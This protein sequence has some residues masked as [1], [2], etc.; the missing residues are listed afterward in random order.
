[1]ESKAQLLSVKVCPNIQNKVSR[2]IL[3]DAIANPE[4]VS[5]WKN[6]SNK[7]LTIKYPRMVYDSKYNN[8]IFRDS[9]LPVNIYPPS[10]GRF[11]E[12]GID[13]K[14]YDKIPSDLYIHI[15]SCRVA[16]DTMRLD[17]SKSEVIRHQNIIDSETGF[18][19]GGRISRGLRMV[20]VL[21]Y[22]FDSEG[23]EIEELNKD[24]IKIVKCNDGEF[25]EG[26]LLNIEEGES[27]D[28]EL[29]I[30]HQFVDDR[31]PGILSGSL[32]II[33]ESGK[34][35][36]VDEIDEAAFDSIRIC[37]NYKDKYCDSLNGGDNYQFQFKEQKNNKFIFD[38]DYKY[39]PNTEAPL[40]NGASYL[41][42]LL[43]YP[44][45]TRST[46]YSSGIQ[47]IFVPDEDM[48]LTFTIPKRNTSCQEISGSG[49]HRI[50]FVPQNY[51][52]LS[53]FK[54]SVND[55]IDD[56]RKVSMGAITDN[57]SF[58]INEDLTQTYG[59][60]FDDYGIFSCDTPWDQ[61]ADC[62]GTSSVIISDQD[63]A[64]RSTARYHNVSLLSR[65]VSNATAHELGHSI[66]GLAD[67]YVEE[68][69]FSHKAPNC[70]SDSTCPEWLPDGEL[71]CF[72]GCTTDD[73]YRPT[74]TS[75][76]RNPYNKFFNKPSLKAWE[77]EL[78][79][80]NPIIE[81]MKNKAFDLSDFYHTAIKVS[82]ENKD[83]LLKLIST[84]IEDKYPI[85]YTNKTFGTE[86]Y[87]FSVLNS[88]GRQIYSGTV[89]Y[90]LKQLHYEGKITGGDELVDPL[91]LYIP[92]SKQAKKV[93]FYDKTGIKKLEITVPN[94]SLFQIRKTRLSLCSNGLCDSVIGENNQSCNSDC[95]IRE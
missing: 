71:G 78:T 62:G 84:T 55:A 87:N 24:E 76:M 13:V 11:A 64:G 33:D 65:A 44:P 70:T 75:I 56:F 66:A 12:I 32:E 39:D 43:M 28:I 85:Y 6:S 2:V 41:I 53:D 79:K 17:C 3:N 92:Y 83:G 5:Q 82:L 4:K 77:S 36:T 58:V 61:R 63:D 10:S 49:W 48:R 16:S 54:E 29:E 34:N 74:E 42:K 23:Y 94:Q 27:Y 7:Q 40:V 59:C 69:R 93:I 20:M 90:L 30:R 50:V 73:Y 22:L 67:E 89:P 46:S 14:S 88:L 52:N 9:C 81:L 15:I 68:G 26:C 8:L 95:I 18:K 60:D 45:R 19:T 80:E 47:N 37:E 1:L 91:I 51:K 35:Y 31:I 38:F 25:N 57:L 21:P 72:K 86:N